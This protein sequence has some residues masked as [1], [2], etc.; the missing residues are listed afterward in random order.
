[1]K[2]C[3]L[4]TEIESVRKRMA[5]K[6]VNDFQLERDEKYTGDEVE[7][8]RIVSED[9]SHYILIKGMSKKKQEEH[10]DRYELESKIKKEKEDDLSKF[11]GALSQ[12]T[13]QSDTTSEQEKNSTSSAGVKRSFVT[14]KVRRSDSRKA[15]R[16][17]PA[18]E[19]QGRDSNESVCS[20]A[21][22]SGLENDKSFS[23]TKRDGEEDS[24]EEKDLESVEEMS[25]EGKCELS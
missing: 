5:K 23:R 22:K 14:A 7:A 17:R 25:S 12:T 21:G 6:T 15:K 11:K 3:N 20:N 10:A 2:Q 9:A 8:R 18:R 24:E 19:C 16:P 1:M 13:S 4:T